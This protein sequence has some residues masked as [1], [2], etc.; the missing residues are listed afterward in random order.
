M[1]AFRVKIIWCAYL[2]ALWW[3]QFFWKEQNVWNIKVTIHVIFI[4]RALNF[5]QAG[6]MAALLCWATASV[7]T[8]VFQGFSCKFFHAFIVPRVGIILNFPWSCSNFCFEKNVWMYSCKIWHDTF[9]SFHIVA[10]SWQGFWFVQYFSFFREYT[11]SLAA[12]QTDQRVVL[13][14]HLWLISDPGGWLLPSV[15]AG[16]GKWAQTETVRTISY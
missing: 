12:L 15:T 6:K 14:L 5:S 3:R 4:M 16:F 8:E 13:L 10:S 7:P 9:R 2:V 1:T 11:F